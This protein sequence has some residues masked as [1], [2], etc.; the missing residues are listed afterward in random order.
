MSLPRSSICTSVAGMLVV[1]ASAQAQEMPKPGPEHQA[2]SVFLGKWSFDG[3][4]KAG[5][6]GPGGKI[7]FT[8]SCEWFEG[9]FAVVCRSEGKSPM[10]P[11]KSLS[12]MTFDMEKRSYTYYAVETGVPPFMANGHRDGK[13]WRWQTEASMGGGQ[14]MKT[15]V[16]VTEVSPTATTFEMKASMDGGK[17]WAPVMEGK[18]TKVSS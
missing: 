17:T 4:A 15:E 2:M 3:E 16:T 8:E 7:T 13:A 11:T 1:C 14:T 12:I 10:G 6:M 18:S 9:G 5:P